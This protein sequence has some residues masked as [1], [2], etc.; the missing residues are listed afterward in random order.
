VPE[1]E[2]SLLEIYEFF[3]QIKTDLR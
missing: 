1:A 2:A 3:T